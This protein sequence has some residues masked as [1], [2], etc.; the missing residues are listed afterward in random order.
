[1][2]AET[3]NPRAFPHTYAQDSGG[4]NGMSLRDYFA[5]AALT[6]LLQQGYDKFSITEW[7]NQAYAYA[8]GML[9]ARQND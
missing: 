5:A 3:T 9:A 6:G 2:S 7:T 4:L 1:M 8:D